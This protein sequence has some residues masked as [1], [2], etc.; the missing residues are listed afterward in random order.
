M[1]SAV[2]TVHIPEKGETFSGVLILVFVMELPAGGLY[3]TIKP[4][5]IFFPEKVR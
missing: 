5:F 2:Q 3:V 1:Q 4:P